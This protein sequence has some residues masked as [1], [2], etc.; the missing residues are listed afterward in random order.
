MADERWPLT[1]IRRGAKVPDDGTQWWQELPEGSTAEPIRGVGYEVVEV[2]PS[3]D[4][5]RLEAERDYLL[6]WL[7]G[8]DAE[9]R[10]LSA[11]SL[12]CVAFGAVEDPPREPSDCGD[13]ARCERAFE[14][15]PPH[16]QKRV[17]PLLVLWR[18]KVAEKERSRGR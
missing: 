7:G 15:M 16:L 13:L 8:F 17:L 18:D 14:A 1:L 5:E 4:A 10:G 9:L 12:T 2:V 3:S 6:R 11:D